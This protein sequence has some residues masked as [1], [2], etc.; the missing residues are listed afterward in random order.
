MYRVGSDLAS[1]SAAGANNVT[2][3]D[4]SPFA[5]NDTVLVFDRAKPNGEPADIINIAGQVLTLDTNL[6]V[7]FD[8]GYG[9]GNQGAAVARPGNGTFDCDVLGLTQ[10]AYGAATDGTDGGC[11]V[12]VV[13]L[14]SGCGN[15]PYREAF[16]T[17]AN[18]V[19]FKDV[20]FS[21][22]GKPNYLFVCSAAYHN[23]KLSTTY[24]V[25]A[26]AHNYVYVYI[27]RF[28]DKFPANVAE[29]SQETVV[30]ECGHHFGLSEPDNGHVDL[31]VVYP[32]HENSDDCV[33]SYHR[34]RIDGEAEF[35]GNAT[36]CIR[37]IRGRDDG[38]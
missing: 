13:I 23:T 35:C 29:G 8:A 32:N 11:F 6:T 34:N 17:A 30:H 31:N 14:P 9:A 36:D 12:E 7:S 4:A 26:E 37:D 33:M 22:K 18:R 28:E 25:S 38:I 21:N 2:V 5:V 27:A 20:W 24:G 1:D 16:G 15:V 3:V 10:G 19:A